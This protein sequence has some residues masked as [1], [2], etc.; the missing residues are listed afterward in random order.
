MAAPMDIDTNKANR[1]ILSATNYKLNIDR[2]L[3]KKL[4][5]CTEILVEYEYT[6]GGIRGRLDTAS[7]EVLNI[8]CQELYKNLPV[9]DGFC[10]FTTTE[11]KQGETIVQHT[12]KVRRNDESGNTVGY[13]LNLYLTN[14]TILLNG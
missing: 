9:E 8:A 5:R 4:K 13:T 6:N 14:N 1:Q 2:A 10:I 3:K 11:D 7:F 12:F